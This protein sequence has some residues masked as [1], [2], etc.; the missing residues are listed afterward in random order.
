MVA[1][2]I[3]EDM[4]LQCFWQLVHVAERLVRGEIR[5]LTFVST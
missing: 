1:Q 2:K 4:S 3:F 5:R